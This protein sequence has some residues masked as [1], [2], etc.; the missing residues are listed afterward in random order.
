M[1]VGLRTNSIA[2]G[3]PAP[4][5]IP[6]SCPAPVPSSGACGSTVRSRSI[7]AVVE[8]GRRGPGLLADGRAEVARRPRRPRA[9]VA[10]DGVL[11]GPAGVQPGGRRG[12]DGVHPAGDDQRL[13]DGRHAAV[14]WRRRVRAA[15]TVE[16]SPIMA[17]CRSSSRVVPAWLASPGKSIRHR[18]CGQ[19]SVPIATGWPRSISPRPCSTCSSTK[20][21]IR[22][23]ASGSGPIAAG[24]RPARAQGVGHRD[25]VGVG[26]PA[27]PGRP[28]SRR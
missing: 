9:T 19:M 1:P 15:S 27:V 7:R 12:R 18:P 22:R 21:P 10:A 6:A 26:Q 8:A 17:S 11:V 25:A 5:R 2:A 24:S 3:I 14:A 16:A 13:A 28:S 23:S 4:A 20:A